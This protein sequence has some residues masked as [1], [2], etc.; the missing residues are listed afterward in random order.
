MHKRDYRAAARPGL[1]LA[2]PPAEQIKRTMPSGVVKWIA[3]T[4]KHN[5]RQV[6]A[7][8]KLWYIPPSSYHLGDERPILMEEIVHGIRGNPTPT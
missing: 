8:E 1:S 3:F 2:G 5:L 6:D 4:P 7:S